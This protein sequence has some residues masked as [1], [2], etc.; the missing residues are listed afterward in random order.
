MQEASLPRNR[1]ARAP[2]ASFGTGARR[3]SPHVS[4]Y[5]ERV[6]EFEGGTMSESTGSDD[7]HAPLPISAIESLSLCAK[8]GWIK[9]STKAPTSVATNIVVFISLHTL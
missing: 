3:P 2:Q 4:A 9:R 8:T 1:Q 6:A 7:P 5:E